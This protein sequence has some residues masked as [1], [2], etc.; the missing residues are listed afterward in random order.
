M[1][2]GPRG[3]CLVKKTEVENLSSE[4]GLATL[5]R[6]EILLFFND[7]FMKIFFFNIDFKRVMQ[8]LRMVTVKT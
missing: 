1:C 5:F 2:Q 6:I 8:Q 4:T 7:I 3:S